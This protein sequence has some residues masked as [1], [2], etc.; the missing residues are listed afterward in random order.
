MI[1]IEK[2]PVPTDLEKLVRDT[3]N[4]RHQV[5][6]ERIRSNFNNKCYLCEI[7]ESTS[8]NIEHF[9][10]HRGNDKLKYDWNN[11]YFACSHCNGIKGDRYDNIL[12]PLSDDIESVINFNMDAI[13]MAKV[14]IQSNSSNEKV[15]N[16][17][18]LLDEIYNKSSKLAG[19]RTEES[20]N[21][22]SKLLKEL[23]NFQD[24]LYIY[25]DED[26]LEEDREKSR[27]EI[28]KHLRSK[29]QFTAFKRCLIRGN[30]VIFE[31][32]KN[33]FR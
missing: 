11:L 23:R 28:I 8:I 29:S 24:S 20:R 25:Y 13:P 4:Y 18:M 19:V 1:S 32:F 31:E 22:R 33:E 6:V 5:V 7:K 16:T 27:K 9:I 17:V 10:P 14:I 3:K 2:K 26:E 21:L 12:D 30:E 15:S